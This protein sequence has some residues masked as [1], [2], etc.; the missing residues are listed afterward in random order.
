MMARLLVF[1]LGYSGLAA[2]RLAS[3]RGADVTVVTRSPGSAAA[4]A[5]RR[6]GIGVAPFAAPG[7]V[8][9]THLL[10]TAAPEEGGDPVLAAHAEAI[11]AA[12]LSWIGY[13]STTG[14]YGNRGGAWVDETSL[15]SP[16]Q[17]RSLRRA[18]AERAWAE[19]AARAGAGLDLI[20][21]GG[22]YGPGRSPLDEVRA[23]TTRRVVKPGHSFSRIHVDDIAGLVAGAMARP[24]AVPVR[25][26]HGVDDAPAASAEVIAEAARL[27]GLPLPPEV[28][29]EE[30]SARMSPMALSF[31]SENRKVSNALTKA[32]TGWA[33]RCPTY[34]EGLAAILAAERAASAE[35]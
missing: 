11:A 17:P 25:V 27:L 6:E 35:R 3:S 32:A 18:A 8:G 28:P 26:L 5:L 1:G 31:W 4:E 12:P 7:L 20:R 9:V 2:A 15:P 13:L 16:T 23:G 14:V 21:L 24:P 34:R 33:L 22:I 10:A 30:A 29:F 19:V